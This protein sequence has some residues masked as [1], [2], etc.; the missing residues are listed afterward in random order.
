MKSIG[1]IRKVDELGRIV[2]PIEIRKNFNIEEG[3]P[4]QIFVEGSKIILQKYEEYECS[5][6]KSRI[7][8]E[9]KFCRYCGKELR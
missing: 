5:S 8:K 3:T 2:I 4:I 6:C 1:I 9:D 7:A